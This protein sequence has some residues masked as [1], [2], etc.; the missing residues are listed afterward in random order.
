MKQVFAALPTADKIVLLALFEVLPVVHS[1]VVVVQTDAEVFLK[2]E[3]QLCSE[4]CDLITGERNK[5]NGKC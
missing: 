3:E 2:T 4:L 1:D 5:R